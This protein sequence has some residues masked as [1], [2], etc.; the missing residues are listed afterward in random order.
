LYQAQL[1]KSASQARYPLQVHGLVLWLGLDAAALMEALAHL[2]YTDKRNPFMIWVPIHEI[3]DRKHEQQRML[4]D[5]SCSFMSISNSKNVN[6]DGVHPCLAPPTPLHAPSLPSIS[7][8]QSSVRII[9][10]QNVN[11]PLHS[12]TACTSDFIIFSCDGDASSR[13][14]SSPAPSCQRKAAHGHASAH[15][16]FVRTHCE[17]PLKPFR[18]CF[19]ALSVHSLHAART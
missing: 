16:R 11:N 15:V 7:E 18:F 10:A 19:P 1:L 13:Q 3:E 12:Y 9:F 8:V 17:E 4:L 6:P 14:L 5:V 2:L